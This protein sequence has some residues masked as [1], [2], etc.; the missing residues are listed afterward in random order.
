M[1]NGKPKQDV[2]PDAG[3]PSGSIGPY[4]IPKKNPMKL[5][6]PRRLRAAAKPVEGM[7]DYSIKV[8]VPLV[9]VD[10]LVTTKERPVCSRPEEGQFP[11]L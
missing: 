1:G 7:P 6:H 4:T 11:H 5:R 9:N 8:N 2:P 3:G 10:V